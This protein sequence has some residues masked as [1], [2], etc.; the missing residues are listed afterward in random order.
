LEINQLFK[1]LSNPKLP[2]DVLKA[3]IEKVEVNFI[4]L[5][6]KQHDKDM[7]NE[8][9]IRLFKK[10]NFS[11]MSKTF[12]TLMKSSKFCQSCKS[13]RSNFMIHSSIQLEPCIEGPTSVKQL[14]DIY[15]DTWQR[16]CKN[17]NMNETVSPQIIYPAPVFIISLKRGLDPKQVI[18]ID[19][20]IS[21]SELV[22]PP[23]S[24]YKGSIDANE[25]FHNGDI[26][27]KFSSMIEKESTKELR[28][29]IKCVIY[30]KEGEYRSCVMKKGESTFTFY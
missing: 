21:F 14:L 26:Q 9:R 4:P 2:H 12:N 30:R 3:L 23:V 25:S 22:A 15:Y 6:S 20:V 17:C 16:Q 13:E 1:Y 7:S 8:K 10:E 5:I 27:E 19:P 24:S 29:R 28:Y 11:L 18:T